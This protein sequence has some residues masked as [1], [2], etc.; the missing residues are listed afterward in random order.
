MSTYQGNNRTHLLSPHEPAS[1][2]THHPAHQLI[3]VT[4][5]FLDVVW[6]SMAPLNDPTVSNGVCVCARLCVIDEAEDS[7]RCVSS[8][9][10]HMK[11]TYYHISDGEAVGEV[12]MEKTSVVSGPTLFFILNFKNLRL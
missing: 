3:T 11:R 9:R 4:D 10:E 5:V 7:Q 1:Q 2:H 6:Q 8:N 12:K